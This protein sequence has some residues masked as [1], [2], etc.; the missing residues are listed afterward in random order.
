MALKTVL[1]AL[2]TKWGIL[3]VELQNAIASDNTTD[4]NGDQVNI[5]IQG[6]GDDPEDDSHKGTASLGPTKKDD[7]KKGELL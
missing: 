1:K 4:R 5:D 7:N 3:S 6:L 2:L